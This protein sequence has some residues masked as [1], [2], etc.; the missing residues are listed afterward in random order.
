MNKTV[1]FDFIGLFSNFFDLNNARRVP[2]KSRKGHSGKRVDP[3]S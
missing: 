3:F 1:F 2:M